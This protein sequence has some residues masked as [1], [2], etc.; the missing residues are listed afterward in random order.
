MK[1]QRPMNCICRRLI[2]LGAAA[3]LVASVLGEWK[4][5]AADAATNQPPYARVYVL[6]VGVN[7]YPAGSGFRPLRFAESD[8]RAVA[9][10][11]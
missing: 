7:G 5:I 2:W 3:S 11:F 10:L 1:F 9:H 8:A 6:A 4:S